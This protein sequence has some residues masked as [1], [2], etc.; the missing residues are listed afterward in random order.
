M[1]FSCSV[2]TDGCLIASIDVAAL[3]VDVVDVV[4]VVAVL[5][6]VLA[7]QIYDLCFSSSR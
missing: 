2:V 6:V 5:M 4:A 1:L 3:V 7:V